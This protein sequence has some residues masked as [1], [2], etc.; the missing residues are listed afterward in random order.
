MRKKLYFFTVFFLILSI[1]GCTGYKP[2][3]SSSNTK[4]KITD[5]EIT[6]DKNLGNQIY[7]RLYNLTRS[8][9]DSPNTKNIYVSIEVSKA[10]KAAVKNSAGKILSYKINLSTKINVRDDVSNNQIL[11]ETFVFSSTYTVQD[12]YS[13]TIK[14]ENKSLENLINET[15]EDL[16]IKLIENI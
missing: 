15:Y 1:S 5:Y 6:G 7:S 12:Q 11:N 4:F 9:D 16:L 3:F 8:A 2:I 14:L 10:K 13:E